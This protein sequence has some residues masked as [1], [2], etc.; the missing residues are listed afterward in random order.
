M[1]QYRNEKLVVSGFYK[2]YNRILEIYKKLQLNYKYSEQD[3]V[4]MKELFK[5][6]RTIL[7]GT[8]LKCVANTLKS[9]NPENCSIDLLKSHM[10]NNLI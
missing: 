10:K 1:K 7:T 3:I 4:L 2:E 5:N 8:N 9:T 6:L